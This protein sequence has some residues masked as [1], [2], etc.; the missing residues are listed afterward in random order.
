MRILPSL[1]VI[2]LTLGLAA[3]V[4]AQASPPS[5]DAGASA[6]AP[7]S[8]SPGAA[9]PA[10]TGSAGGGGGHT[11]MNITLQPGAAAALTSGLA[12]AAAPSDS[13]NSA[14]SAKDTAR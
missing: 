13:R 1:A 9:A 3:P 6:P 4:F 2:A 7:S 5:S 10:D 12:Q 14:P 11:V 8:S